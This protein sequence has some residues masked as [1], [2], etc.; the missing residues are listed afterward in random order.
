MTKFSNTNSI[1]LPTI[2]GVEITTDS[3]GRFN[4]NALANA[5]IAKGVTKDVRPNEW[6]A[7]QTTE[8]MAEILITE[9][10]PMQP[11][12]SSPG[13]YGGTFVHELLA[14]SYA[15]WISP[16]FQLSV[17]QT[18][19][20]YRSNRTKESNLNALAPSAEMR[21]LRQIFHE[22]NRM[23]TIAGFKGNQAVLSGQKLAI[24]L[25]GVDPLEIIGASHLV[26][27]RQE[28]LITPTEIGGRLGD[29]SS[30][31]ANKLLES[32]GFQKQVRDL[33]GNKHWE[34]T[35]KGEKAGGVYLDTSKKHS[36]GTAIRQLKWGSG[37]VKELQE[38]AQL[39]V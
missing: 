29:Y 7:L 38:T 5:A 28:S 21:E 14:V 6:L 19:L 33:K 36:D 16:S 18:F 1:A 20:D 32:H 22:G 15:G 23:A 10:S 34:M 27:P 30:Q 31:A 24:R 26:A 9:Y 37:I 3:E 39:M 13:R 12:V 25:T 17:N 4:L 11:I 8:D 35:A 2:A